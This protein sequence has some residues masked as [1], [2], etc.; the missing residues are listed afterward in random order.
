MVMVKVY[1]ISG[2]PWC[3]KTKAYLDSKNIPFTDIDVESDAAGREALTKLSPEMSV[4]V[5]EID[6]KVILG[7]DKEQIDAALKL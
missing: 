4:P 5:L 2:C 7:F 6:G 3:K 1:S